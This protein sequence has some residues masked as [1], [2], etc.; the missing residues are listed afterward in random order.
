VLDKAG[1][2]NGIV[3]LDVGCGAGLAVRMAADLGAKVTGIDASPG[4]L[5]IAEERSPQCEF[6][7]G[8]MDRLPFPDE[9]FDLVTGF[10]SF[11][12]A[13][14]PLGALREAHR[15][16]KPGGQVA[17]GTW[18]KPEDCDTAEFLEAMRELISS[19]PSTVE[20][21]FALSQD[22]TLE[23]LC[24]NAGLE[25]LLTEDVDCPFDYPDLSTALTALMSPGPVI[26]AIN[27]SGE[28][29]VR[30]IVIKALA[31]YRTESGGYL[32]RNKFRYLVSRRPSE[33]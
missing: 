9:S 20:G 4:L 30:N 33:T 11:Q 16:V 13:E 24:R 5:T 8:S 2:R 27:E 22:G 21:P 3:M 26:L 29:K 6:H 12:F 25:P 23:T 1:V 18:A 10:N 19:A 31:P 32:M 14:D 15:V 17:V 7:L 28:T